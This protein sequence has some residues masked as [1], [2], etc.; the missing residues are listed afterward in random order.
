MS[1]SQVLLLHAAAGLCSAALGFGFAS[2]SCKQAGT[3]TCKRWGAVAG[4]LLL[5]VRSMGKYLLI[6][7]ISLVDFVLFLPHNIIFFA[8]FTSRGFFSSDAAPAASSF[9]SF[10]R[11][12]HYSV[13][14]LSY[15]K[16]E[17]FC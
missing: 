5:F 16:R 9:I 14:R 2:A 13:P 15:S 4:M 1:E 12:V 10:L 6:P 8:D 17:P 7:A 3:N 11:C